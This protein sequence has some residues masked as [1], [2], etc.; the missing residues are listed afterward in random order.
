MSFLSGSV[1]LKLL[2]YRLSLNFYIASHCY[3]TWLGEGPCLLL[4]SAVNSVYSR[5]ITL[6]VVKAWTWKH[7][8]PG[9]L[10]GR[11]AAPAAYLFLAS[12]C[13]TSRRASAAGDHHF[14][15]PNQ[16]GGQLGL[17]E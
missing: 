2:L 12:V 13:L 16:W 5:D 11:A 4:Q 10:R 7:G 6:P 3:K 1:V 9:A 8:H 17:E 15:F 14:K